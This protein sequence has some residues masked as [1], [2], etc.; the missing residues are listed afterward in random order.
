MRWV[1]D[2]HRVRPFGGS[3]IVKSLQR[4]CVRLVHG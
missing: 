3:E 4:F 2:Y 1:F